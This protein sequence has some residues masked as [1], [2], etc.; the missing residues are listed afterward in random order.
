MNLTI[1]GTAKV[2]NGTD[3]TSHSDA[4][5]QIASVIGYGSAGTLTLKGTA[6]VYSGPY[7]YCAIAMTKSGTNNTATLYCAG[8]SCIYAANFDDEYEAY[9]MGRCI[10]ARQGV[11]LTFSGNKFYAASKYVAVWTHG[12]ESRVNGTLH[13]WKGT[14]FSEAK[15]KF[16]K[17][18]AVTSHTGTAD[19]KTI[20]VMNSYNTTEDY[21]T[22]YGYTYTK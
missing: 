11:T 1:G 16:Y 4:D 15:E 5:T 2:G 13:V 20:Q 21:L 10:G 19:N 9:P 22:T 7:S 14:F 6:A 12:D 8:S 3:G 18:G 17:N